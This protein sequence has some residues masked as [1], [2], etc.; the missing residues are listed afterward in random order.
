MKNRNRLKEYCM[1]AQRLKEALNSINYLVLKLY[2]GYNESKYEPQDVDIF[3][4]KDPQK[5]ILVL[6][7]LKE[8]F[9][10]SNAIKRKHVSS[11][12]NVFVH[13]YSLEMD[14]YLEVIFSPI[15]I[16]DGVPREVKVT[17]IPWC[18]EIEVPSF[19]S[20]LNAFHILMHAFRHKRLY[21]YEIF[22][23][24]KELNDF[25]GTDLKNFLKYIKR[26]GLE[27]LVIFLLR[28]VLYYSRLISRIPVQQYFSF[29]RN[30]LKI[31]RILAK[32]K[33]S[34]SLADFMGKL[35]LRRASHHYIGLWLVFPLYVFESLALT[36]RGSCKRSINALFKIV[37]IYLFYEYTMALFDKLGLL[38]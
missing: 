24:V 26:S 12:I 23:L 32:K 5:I 30:T 9:P 36:F 29:Y 17:P 15:L 37:F 4:G 7:V 21:D 10:E 19:S 8:T 38:K 3:I 6:K 18:E 14:L 28:L 34:M 27:T 33:P 35:I 11:S 2:R 16:L 22:S 31:L 1:I 20:P 13:G 25:N